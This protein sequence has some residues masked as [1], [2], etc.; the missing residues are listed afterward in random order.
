MSYQNIF[1]FWKTF[2]ILLKRNILKKIH[3][4][5]LFFHYFFQSLSKFRVCRNLKNMWNNEKFEV[6][7][8][9][10][11]KCEKLKNLQKFSWKWNLP[12]KIYFFQIFWP[13]P[14]LFAFHNNYNCLIIICF[15]QILQFFS[16]MEF[17]KKKN[18]FLKF[19]TIRHF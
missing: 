10:S 14:I 16:K 18:C 4:F 3:F 19:S 11:T 1:I 13:F 5:L 6:I 7:M 12:T 2:Y 15:S 17:F 8:K 9:I